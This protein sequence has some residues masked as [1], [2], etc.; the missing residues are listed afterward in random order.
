MEDIRLA[1]LKNLIIKAGGFLNIQVIFHCTTYT[2][3]CNKWSKKYY[4][5]EKILR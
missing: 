4:V 5:I 2:H 1:Y 3:T